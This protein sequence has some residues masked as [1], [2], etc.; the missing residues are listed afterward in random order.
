MTM[1]PARGIRM[2]PRNILI[3]PPNILWTSGGGDGGGF[4]Y[5]IFR[6]IK[7]L[8]RDRD[9]GDACII[10]IYIDRYCPI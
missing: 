8:M 7:M 6:R 9:T 4:R 2:C 1:I 10:Y 5:G 3:S